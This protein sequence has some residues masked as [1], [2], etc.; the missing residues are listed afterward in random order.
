MMDHLAAWQ[1]VAGLDEPTGHPYGLGLTFAAMCVFFIVL[2]LIVVLVGRARDRRRPPP[3]PP[4]YPILGDKP[5]KD[6]HK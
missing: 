4:V 6:R 5:R 1:P 3:P 2:F